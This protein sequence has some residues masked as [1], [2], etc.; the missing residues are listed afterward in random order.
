MSQIGICALAFSSGTQ[1]PPDNSPHNSTFQML[2]NLSDQL[3][4]NDHYLGRKRISKSTQGV[5]SWDFSENEA[6]RSTPDDIILL[7]LDLLIRLKTLNRDFP[8]VFPDENFW[9][10][11]LSNIRALTGRLTANASDAQN[12]VENR[13]E[14][15]KKINEQFTLLERETFTHAARSHLET[16]ASRD[17]AAPFNVEIH[18]G[19]PSATIRIMPFLFYIRCKAFKAPLDNQWRELQEGTAHL[20]GTYRYLAEWPTDLGG[21]TEGTFD[22]E[23]DRVLRF[24]PTKP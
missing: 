6:A 15:V 11:S 18:I 13:T 4:A 24:S 7:S 20:I 5:L 21:A 14:I 10:Q 23:E 1:I 12:K 2:N 3:V 17:P 22:V 16:S 8:S 9:N 19:P